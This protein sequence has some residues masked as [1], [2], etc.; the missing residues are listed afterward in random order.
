MGKD[1]VYYRTKPYKTTRRWILA[2]VKKEKKVY[3]TSFSKLTQGKRYFAEGL[4]SAAVVTYEGSSGD[5]RG[6]KFSLTSDNVKDVPIYAS[7]TKTLTRWGLREM[8]EEK[9]E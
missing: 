9:K 5:A 7:N 2:K 8:T 6:H 1:L 4:T 3:I